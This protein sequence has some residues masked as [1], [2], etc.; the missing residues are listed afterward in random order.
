M[1]LSLTL[2]VGA[3]LLIR[4]F[5]RLQDVDTGFRTD[6]ILTLRIALPS[7]K[8]ARPTQTR[9]FY[10]DLLERVRRLPGVDSAGGIT[11]L[12]LSRTG[13]SGTTTVDSQAVEPKDASFEADQRPVLPG[14]FEALAIRLV[15]GR[16]FDQRDNEN[17]APVAIIDET[18]A[19]TYW[20]HEDPLGKRIKQGDRGSP[21]P[22]RTIVGVVRHVRYRTLES[23]SRVEFYWPYEQTS[24]PLGTMSL[25]IHTATD[26]R[27]LAGVVQKEVLAID[28][29]QPVYR[30]RTMAELVDESMA[31]RRLSM[32]LLAIFA[33]IALALAAIGIYGIMSYSVAQRA[34]EVG[35]RMAL[36]AGSGDV[37]RMVLG[38]SLWL[39][40]AGIA[41][42][43]AGSLALT[44]FLS[45]LLFSIRAVDPLTFLSVSLIL[46]IVAL[47]ASFVP[48][49][50]ATTVD[51]V[52][53]L[54]QE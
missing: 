2:L 6:G 4:S 41:A 54:R 27:A 7:Q 15:R 16:Y 22:W 8:Y 3:G 12:P 34:H 28:P 36:G 47:V 53:A 43:L 38:Q 33:G 9:A 23:P 35:I 21:Q 10:R 24:F 19:N 40:F 31:R 30:I 48:A 39:A 25:A 50:R 45:S 51:P 29:D 26:P 32:F 37:V 5:L 20:P 42:G 17:S 14:Y 13:W 1:A 44:N 11:G 49:Y 52:N 46:A 18:M